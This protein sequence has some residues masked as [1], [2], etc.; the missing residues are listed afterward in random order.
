MNEAPFAPSIVEDALDI[1]HEADR[2]G[3]SVRIFGSIGVYLHCQGLISEYRKSKR[4]FGDIDVAAPLV[5]VHAVSECLLS[6]GYEEETT[7]RILTGGGRRRYLHVNRGTSV[8]LALDALRFCQTLD[9][10]RRLQADYPTLSV[11]DLLLSKIQKM[12]LEPKDRFDVW[13]LLDEHEIGGSDEETV[14]LGY[15]AALCSR[16][17]RWWRCLRANVTVLLRDQ[18]QPGGGKANLIA[19]LREIQEGVEVAPKSL[20]WRLRSIAGDSISWSRHVEQV[21]AAQPRSDKSESSLQ[22]DLGSRPCKSSSG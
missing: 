19:K 20:V 18:S 3:I 8:D 6:L 1:V 22:D 13:A 16:S 12:D 15:I 14:N 5:Q 10:R 11:T 7:Y 21:V 2:R 4:S 17:W 9:L